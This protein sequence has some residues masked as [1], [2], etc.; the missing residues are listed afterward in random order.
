MPSLQEYLSSLPSDEVARISGKVSSEY[1]PN[2]LVREYSKRD[3]DPVIYLENPNGGE[4]PLATN[5]FASTKRIAGVIGVSEE[6]FQ[7]APWAAE[8]EESG[9]PPKIA[10]QGPVQEVVVKGEQVDLLELPIAVHHEQD[11]APYITAGIL[12]V[13]DPATG[14]RNMSFSRIQVRDRNRVGI[15]IHSRGTAWQSFAAAE[16]AGHDLQVAV[17]IGA[18]PA[19]YLAAS[20]KVSPDVDE[21]DIAGALLKEPVEL[22]KCLSSDLEVPA[23]AEI[24]LEGRI[25]ANVREDEG[26]FGEYTGYASSNSTRNVLQVDAL[27]R[28]ANPVYLDISA[29]TTEHR[30]LGSSFKKSHVLARLREVA[31]TVRD[32]NYPLSGTYYNAFLSM[33]K[34]A[35]GQSRHALMLLFGLDSY[36]KNAVVVDDDID[37]YDESEVLWAIATRFQADKDVFIVPNVLCNRLDPSSA[38]GT[39]AKMGLDATRPLGWRGERLSLPREAEDWARDFLDHRI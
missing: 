25:L 15:S 34:T 17:V 4:I 30:R 11:T 37:V 10:S 39:S 27:T 13:K 16:A 24:V 14:I 26:P 35:E 2:A 22:V 1:C 21:F 28:R 9:I 3:S 19:I 18:H 36:V 33:R 7:R 20:A 32:L 38:D 12:V 29:G 31:P 8:V 23:E 5:L 6:D